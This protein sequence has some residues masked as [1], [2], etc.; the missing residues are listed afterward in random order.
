MIGIPCNLPSHGQFTGVERYLI[1]LLREMMRLPIPADTRFELYSSA[2]V[3]LF[4]ALPTGWTNVV[5]PWRFKGWT[6]ACLSFYLLRHAPTILFVPIHE[7][8]YFTGRA[9]VVATVHDIAFAIVPNCYAPREVRRQH[10]A[11]RHV[12]K[13]ASHLLAV[14]NSTKQDLIRV[15]QV[16]E[17]KI[18]VTQLASASTLVRPDQS[19]T[20]SVLQAFHVTYKN[21]I[22]YV[23][24]LEHKKGIVEFLRV[25]DQYKKAQGLGDP[26]HLVLV[27]KFGYGE[28][29]IKK[30][31]EILGRTDIHIV[32]FVDDEK[33]SALFA[34]ARAF[35]FPTRYEGF[36]IPLL[37]AMQFDL[38]ILTTDLAITREVAG[39]A[40]L[41]ASHDDV[42][43]WI[44]N[45]H[46]VMRNAEVEELLVDAAKQQRGKFS[47]T[48]TA[49]ETM[50]ALSK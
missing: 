26:L 41:Y 28:Q 19:K 24:R 32:G 48:R 15:L 43:A 30:I 11:L 3:T 47:W 49:R 22:L 20:E 33:M 17:S 50:E 10:W 12:I 18:S 38:P 2:P 6:H 23:G 27:G 7:I 13:K 31:L 40:A 45:L 34:G 42:G 9:R 39:A 44:R 35:V 1:E 8:P 4:G 5:L 37:E 29:D 36:G 14:S 25:F 16:P 46:Q 21:Y